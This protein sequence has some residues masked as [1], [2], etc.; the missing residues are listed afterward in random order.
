VQTSRR[1]EAEEVGL[2]I[3]KHVETLNKLTPCGTD[4]RLFTSDVSAK[5]KVTRNTKTRTNIKNPA[6]SNLDLCPSLRISGQLPAPIVN[7]GGDTFEIGR[8]SNFQG[9]VTLTFYRVILHFVHHSSTSTYTP[10][11]IENEKSFCG[12]TYT[13]VVCTYVRTDGRTHFIRSTQKSRPKNASI[14]GPYRRVHTNTNLINYSV[15]L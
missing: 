7:G 8:I 6:R 9:L 5:F 4:G 10:N 3:A 2:C 1:D 14:G 12:R 15:K 11:F 13:Y